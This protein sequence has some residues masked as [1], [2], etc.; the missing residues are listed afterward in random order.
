MLPQ[1]FSFEAIP[2]VIQLVKLVNHGHCQVTEWEF[3][4]ATKSDT[5]ATSS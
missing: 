1:E 2:E 5:H 3:D 4:F